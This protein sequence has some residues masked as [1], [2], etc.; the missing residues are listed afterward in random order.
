M[1]LQHRIELL[2]KLMVNDNLLTVNDYENIYNFNQWFSEE[3]V[4]HSLSEWTRVLTKENISQWLSAYNIPANPHKNNTIAIIMAGNI[5][6]V[7]FHDFICGF[8]TGVDMLIKLSSKDNVLMKLIID[9]LIDMQPE[10]SKH[11]KYI[12]SEDRHVFESSQFDAII[13]TGSNNTNRYFEYYFSKYSNILRKSRHSVAVLTGE[14]SFEE[15]EDLADDVFLYFGLGCR[16]VSKIFVPQNYD[17]NKMGQAFQKYKHLIDNHKYSNNLIYQYALISMNKIVHI[18]FGNLLLL[19]RNELSSGIGILNYEFYNS[20]NDVKEK[21]DIQKNEIQCIVSRKQEV[22]NAVIPFGKS[23]KPELH[24][25]ADN[26]DTINFI[27]NT[28]KG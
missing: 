18:N 22:E 13:A 10:L 27:L 5:P 6:L 7:G 11:I 3:F 24:N 15:L 28:H 12:D 8:L 23:Q 20:L 1:E 17:F 2:S 4:K 21:L 16:N 9:K 19:E 26:I 25:Y 14:E